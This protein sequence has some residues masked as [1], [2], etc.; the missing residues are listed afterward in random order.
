MRSWVVCETPDGVHLLRAADESPRAVEW[1]WHNWI[2]N[3]PGFPGGALSE[4]IP[5]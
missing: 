3:C 1:L 4:K 2:L 5:L